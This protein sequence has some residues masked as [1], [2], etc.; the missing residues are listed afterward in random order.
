MIGLF[1]LVR[2]EHDKAT[3]V[4]QA[5]IMIAATA[6]TFGFQLLL[7]DAISPLLRFVPQV[8]TEEEKEENHCGRESTVHLWMLAWRCFKLL[9][10][11]SITNSAD[12]IFFRMDQETKDS[13]GV[14]LKFQHASLC[15]EKPMIWIAKD[16]LGIS[17]DEISCIRKRYSNVSVSNEHAILDGKGRLKIV[18]DAN[19]LSRII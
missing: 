5:V 11:T 15:I 7:D 14:S 13:T 12:D 3:C 10:P 18:G 1:F 2:D 8:K 4:S 9:A 17:D 16:H 19:K 6:L